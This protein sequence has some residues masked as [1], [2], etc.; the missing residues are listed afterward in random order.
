MHLFESNPLD[1]T[2]GAAQ[3]KWWEFQK[4]K[5]SDHR[6]KADKRAGNKLLK[7]LGSALDEFEKSKPR[8]EDKILKFPQS[9]R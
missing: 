1:D 5:Y 4:L 3:V 2:P 8:V 7:R 9:N 6:T